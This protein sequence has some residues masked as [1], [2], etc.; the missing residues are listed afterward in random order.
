MSVTKVTT[1]SVTLTWQVPREDG[2]RSDTVY[3][4]HCQNCGDGVRFNPNTATFLQTF[5]TMENLVPGTAYRV[6]LYT[7]NGVSSV[8]RERPRSAEILVT[9]EP[10][11]PTTVTSLRITNVRPS[12]IE[13]A[14]SPPR[15]PFIEIEMYEV[16]YFVKS[17]AR[18]WRGNRTITTRNEEVVLSNLAEKTEYGLEVRAKREGGGWGEWT[19]PVF[20]VTGP[21]F[22]S[23][24]QAMTPMSVIMI[25]CLSSLTH[26]RD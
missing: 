4:I 24:S 6:E 11:N 17:E 12:S 3:R 2:G 13:L 10:D 21:V 14:W 22:T 8:A 18:N 16:Q 5:I 19:R 7:E 1:T 26:Y 23:T 20:Q 15:D 9:T 25:I